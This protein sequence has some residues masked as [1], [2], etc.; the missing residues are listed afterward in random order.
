MGITRREL[1]RRVAVRLGIS[2]RDARSITSAVIEE[3]GDA[4]LEDQHVE[5]RGF[6]SFDLKWRSRRRIGQN[7]P[8]HER[9]AREIPG[10]W[11]VVFRPAAGI[12]KRLEKEFEPEN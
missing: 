4:I 5:L 10:K 11:T 8:G 12:A 3:L 9:K 1:A 6:G 2:T 7:L